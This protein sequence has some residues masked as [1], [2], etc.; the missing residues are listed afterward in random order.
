M[1][2]PRPRMLWP[3]LMALFMFAV[4]LALGTWQLRR[5]AW[6]EGILAAIAHAEA[7]PAV[8]LPP[9]P[10]PYMKVSVTGRFRPDL[11]AFFAAEVEETPAG[12]EMGAELI[13]PLERDGAP[14][15]L[16]DRGWIPTSIHAPV[17]WPHGTVTVD[18]YVQA[19][20]RG[21]LFTPPPDLARRQFYALDPQQIG[22]ALGVH[23]APFILMAM[24]PVVPA[25]Y[26]VPAQHLPRP[27]NNHLQ[28]ALTWYALAGG[29]VVVFG[30]W[31][32]GMGR[33]TD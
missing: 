31:A 2:P 8:P 16:V 24:G 20:E 4:L 1:S 9:H 3:G 18:G 5:L 29:L 21:G 12:P 7:S 17:T 30:T 28:Y 6:K 11:A 19:P 27:P 23:A 14:P 32:R 33:G 15:I 22:A 26:P 25:R 10:G 13:V